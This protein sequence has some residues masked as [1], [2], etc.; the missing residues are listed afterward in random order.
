M[1]VATVTMIDCLGTVA[2]VQDCYVS[3]CEADGLA[4][5]TTLNG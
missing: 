4:Q 1:A 5:L 3:W 2:Y